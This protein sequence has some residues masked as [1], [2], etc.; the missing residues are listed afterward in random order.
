MP[1]TPKF[2]YFI[3]RLENPVFEGHPTWDK[4]LPLT[5]SHFAAMLG[6]SGD[7]ILTIGDYFLAA[8]L[9]FE[10]SGLDMI[11]DAFRQRFKNNI[12]SFPQ[13]M[14]FIGIEVKEKPSLVPHQNP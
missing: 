11:G 5:R 10:K 4:P 14:S 12:K 9:F 3:S 6:K 8:R 7:G 13:I 1:T 2:S